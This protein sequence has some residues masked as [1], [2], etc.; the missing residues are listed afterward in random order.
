VTAA[1]STFGV[2]TKYLA[3]AVFVG[4]APP[5]AWNVIL[6]VGAGFAGAATAVFNIAIAGSAMGLAVTVAAPALGR[7]NLPTKLVAALALLGAGASLFSAVNLFRTVTDGSGLALSGIEKVLLQQQS[8]EGAVFAAC[9][10]ALAVL[11]LVSRRSS[12]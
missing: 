10:I 5:A 1:G 7:A 12:A 4:A 2:W 9:T 11:V 3:V 6:L 8:A